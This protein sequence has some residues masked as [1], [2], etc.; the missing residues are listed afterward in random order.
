MGQLLDLIGPITPAS[1][2]PSCEAAKE[3]SAVAERASEKSEEYNRQYFFRRFARQ[4][5]EIDSAIGDF[6]AAVARTFDLPP[7]KLK[8]RPAASFP[9]TPERLPPTHWLAAT[10]CREPPPICSCC[11]GSDWRALTKDPS[12]ELRAWG[13]TTC[14]P[15]GGPGSSDEEGE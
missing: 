15:G 11:G 9:T 8:T 6:V 7:S 13:C 12:A 1:N 3:V 14:R 5:P 2:A 10:Y 4:T